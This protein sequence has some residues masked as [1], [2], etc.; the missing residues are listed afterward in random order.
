MDLTGP[1]SV[2]TWDS[3]IYVLV[4]VEVSYH[5]PVKRLLEGY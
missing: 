1:M 4:V 2:T 5:Y 3:Y